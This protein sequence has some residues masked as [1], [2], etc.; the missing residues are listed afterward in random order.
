MGG[1]VS[2]SCETDF[3]TGGIK[4]GKLMTKEDL[5]WVD[6]LVDNIKPYIYVRLKDKLL[7]LLPNQAYKLN[8]TG[9]FI[10]KEMSEGRKILHILSEKF[11]DNIPNNV[12]DDIHYFFC[13]V[14]DL[15]SGH[16]CNV[17][18]RKSVE[19]KPFSRPHNTLPVLSEIALTYKCN[20]ACKF[21]YAG[22]NCKKEPV[23]LLNVKDKI[24]ET[25]KG[26][27]YKSTVGKTSSDTIINDMST[28]EVKKVLNIIKNHAEVPSVS[29]TGGEPTLR[30]DLVE[31][32]EYATSM[33]IR[34]N[35]I[36]NGTQL[37]EEYIKR[38]V[39]GGLKSAQISLEGGSCK[40]HENLTGVKGS[41]EKT[42]NAI[43]LLLK[44]NIHV[45]TNTTLNQLNVPYVDELIEFISTLGTKRF[46]MNLCIPTKATVAAELSVTY[47]DIVPILE[48]IKVKAEEVGMEFMWYSPTP[49]CIFNP[50][51]AGLGGKSCAACDGLLSVAPNG[52]VLPCSSLPKSVGNILK[53]D[54]D[55]LWRGKKATFWRNKNYAHK[56]CE[57]C[58][59]FTVCTGACP[60]Y[61]DYMG[62]D[63]L[64]ETFKNIE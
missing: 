39:N 19:I 7:I 63:E 58:E 28:E 26:L 2:K 40:V 6:E 59:H 41:F 21:C 54:F 4:K 9:L 18:K 37:N 5:C 27:S 52:D 48:H 30:S 10:L 57:K 42:V 12:I 45:H 22:C 36:S 20:L 32:V 56:K 62:Y 34:V 29:F 13:D 60:I 24:N 31:L 33:G 51:K 16:F 38:L 53:S 61:F 15:V 35:L 25:I 50:V 49:Y 46:S 14:R 64:K 1:Q 44:E 43:K 55:S 3:E 11:G 17:D 8:E 47:T 23:T